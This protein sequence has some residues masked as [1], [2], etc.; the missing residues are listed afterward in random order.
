MNIARARLKL[1]RIEI[2]LTTIPY[3]KH[4][5]LEGLW[6]AN[7]LKRFKVWNQNFKKEES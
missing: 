6:I 3:K 1:A 4:K 7:G 5:N 2:K